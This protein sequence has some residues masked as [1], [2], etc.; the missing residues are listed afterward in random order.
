LSDRIPG[1]CN[2]NRVSPYFLKVPM[3][4]LARKLSGN[5]PKPSTT[6]YSPMAKQAVELQAASY[7][8]TR[9]AASLGAWDVIGIGPVDLVLVQV[10]TRDWPGSTEMDQL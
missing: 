3:E 1:F 6:R 8:C 9:A 7:A 10:N 5:S 4:S 2:E